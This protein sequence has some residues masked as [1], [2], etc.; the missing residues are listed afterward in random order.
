MIRRLRTRRGP[1]DQTDDNL[2]YTPHVSQIVCRRGIQMLA[3]A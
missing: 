1:Y 2:I 3:V